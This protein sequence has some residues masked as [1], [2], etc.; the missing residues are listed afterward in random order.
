MR[1][2]ELETE[3]VLLHRN[4]QKVVYS[5]ISHRGS[6]KEDIDFRI[7][8]QDLVVLLPREELHGEVPVGVGDGGALVDYAP[9]TLGEEQGLAYHLL[10][11]QEGLLGYS[12]AVKGVS[13]KC[14]MCKCASLTLRLRCTMCP[15][16]E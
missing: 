7:L 6:W 16:R 8:D 9:D 3:P 1:E 10:V 12:D 2:I 15:I 5:E 4:L 14:I 11:G 13:C